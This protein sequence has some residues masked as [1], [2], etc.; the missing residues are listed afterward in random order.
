MFQSIP[1]RNRKCNG[2]PFR[3]FCV[4]RL[5]SELNLLNTRYSSKANALPRPFLASLSSYLMPQESAC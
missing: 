1:Q 2:N 3:I 5:V 4:E